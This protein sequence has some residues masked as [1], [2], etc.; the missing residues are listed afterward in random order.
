MVRAVAPLFTLFQ[1]S[2]GLLFHHSTT[3]GQQKLASTELCRDTLTPFA[4]EPNFQKRRKRTTEGFDNTL[5]GIIFDIMF[6][7]ILK[8]LL[9]SLG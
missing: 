2:E 9:E 5:T 6:K 7:D 3:R 1:V 8:E 4:H